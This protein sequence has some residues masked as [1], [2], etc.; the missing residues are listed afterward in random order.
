[1]SLYLSRNSWNKCNP[2]LKILK[3]HWKIKKMGELGIRIDDLEQSLH[4]M[5]EQAGLD[6]PP[7]DPSEH[8][9]GVNNIS[10]DSV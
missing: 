5:I 2:D 1:M 3:A 8:N 7:E 6:P 9:G 10:Q 4:E